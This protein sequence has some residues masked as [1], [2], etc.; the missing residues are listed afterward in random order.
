MALIMQGWSG[1]LRFQEQ[2]A[3]GPILVVAGFPTLEA[4]KPAALG[5]NKFAMLLGDEE[6]DP[7]PPP[8]E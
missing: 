5:K 7:D 3:Q 1:N 6:E 4:K 8:I 2:D